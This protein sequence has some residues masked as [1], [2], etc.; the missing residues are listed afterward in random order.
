MFAIVLG[1]F[2]DTSLRSKD[3]RHTVLSITHTHERHSRA[4]LFQLQRTHA[5]CLP[6]L[7]SFLAFFIRSAPFLCWNA[8]NQLLDKRARRKQHSDFSDIHRI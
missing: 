6:G 4:S 2:V 5:D 1:R 3:D 7:F 8:A